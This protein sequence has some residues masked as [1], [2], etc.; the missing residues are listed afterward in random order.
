MFNKEVIKQALMRTIR[1]D[2]NLV[3]NSLRANDANEVL[4]TRLI[5]D[6]FGG[7]ILKARKKNG[8][9]FYNRI[10]GEIIDFSSTGTGRSLKEEYH[11][12]TSS[13]PEETSSYFVEEDY[14]LLFT[15]FI[16][17]FEETVG[18]S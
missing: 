3:M 10:N 2:N 14:S 8:W 5:Y 18:L 11:N 1:T 12:E 16:Y 9:H 15:E 17:A 7:E 4:S 6:V 13:S